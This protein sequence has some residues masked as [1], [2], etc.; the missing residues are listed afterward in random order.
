MELEFTA[1][2]VTA[3]GELFIHLDLQGLAALLR[4]IE[5]AMSTGRGQLTS[6]GNVGGE[7][8]HG[9]G[10]VTVTFGDKSRPSDDSGPFTLPETEPVRGLASPANRPPLQP[11]A[12][13]P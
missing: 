5:A 13:A 12:S 1:E 4:A 7:I 3:E 10:K 6:P 9:F 8:P 11:S 2:G